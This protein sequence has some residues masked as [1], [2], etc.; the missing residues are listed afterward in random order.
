MN[1]EILIKQS[2]YHQILYKFKIE[3]E[4]YYSLDEK[5]SNLTDELGSCSLHKLLIDCGA[6]DISEEYRDVYDN[7]IILSRF[8]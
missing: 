8:I 3:Q 4:G 7:G 2:E 1:C 5:L 6:Y